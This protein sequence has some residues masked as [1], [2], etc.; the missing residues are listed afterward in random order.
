MTQPITVLPDL[1]QLTVPTPF[2]VG[3]VNVYVARQ[4]D[5]LALVD[6]GPRTLQARAALEEGLAALGHSVRDVSCI[7]VTHAHADH[8]GLAADLVAESGAR[9]LTHPFN[10]P[11]LESFADERERRLAFY[12]ELLGASGVP[13]NVLQMVQSARR[14]IGEYAETVPVAGDVTDG[15]TVML[16]GRAWQVLHTPGHSAGLV[17]LYEPRSR[18]LLS[19]DHLLRDISS[20][21]VAEP[22]PLGRTAR[23]Q[24]LVEY[25]DQ[26]RRVAALDVS[27]AWPGH[28]DPIYNV[29]ELVRQRVEFHARRAGHILELFDGRELTAFHIMHSL[30]PVVDPV[31]FFLAISEVVGHLELLESEGRVRS[32]QRDNPANMC[33]RVVVWQA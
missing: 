22:L 24:P 28:G 27:V 16:A 18:V 20:N 4:A 30:F 7:I 10:R 11:M 21:P 23:Y 32:I 13:H 33:C 1:Y 25:L 12:A 6:C 8:Y 14:S 15:E 9:V 5:G 29:P 26:L 19:A 3:P 2:P 17:C 31:G